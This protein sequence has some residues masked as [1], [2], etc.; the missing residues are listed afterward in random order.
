MS[1]TERALAWAIP[2]LGIAAL[3]L[4]LGLPAWRHLEA[5]RAEIVRLTALADRYEAARLRPRDAT[6]SIAA[7]LLMPT[8]SNAQAQAAL[9]ERV[10]AILADAG[11]VL[12]GLQPQA[13]RTEG[14][15]R[16][17][18]LSV[19]FTADMVALQR[20]LHAFETARPMIAVASA[21]M[22]PRGRPGVGGGLD[23]ALDLVGF[24]P[25]SG[26]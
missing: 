16:D 9:Q 10:K 6:A 24:A 22:R 14:P 23:I 12:I 26:P 20:A 4:G 18:A 25:G 19:Q 11:G 5:G 15:W 17:V 8:A 1:L 2:A 3:W 13:T 7:E 21:E